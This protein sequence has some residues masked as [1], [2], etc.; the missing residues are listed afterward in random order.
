VLATEGADDFLTGHGLER[1]SVCQTEV[2]DAAP[3]GNANVVPTNR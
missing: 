3:L 2:I 1:A